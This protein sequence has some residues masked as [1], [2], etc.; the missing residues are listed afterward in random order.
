M[1]MDRLT[2]L[3]EAAR[4]GHGITVIMSGGAGAGKT[5]LVD[6]LADIA[7][8]GGFI[9]LRGSGQPR[10]VTPY[11]LFEDA[12]AGHLAEPLVPSHAMTRFTELFAVARNG[13][14]LAQARAEG[15][16]VVDTDIMAGMLTAVQSFVSDSFGDM[17]DDNGGAGTGL[18]RLEYRNRKILIE[19]GDGF[20][21]AGVIEGDEH[22]SMQEALA[23]ATTRIGASFGEAIR[24]WD[25]KMDRVSGI[26]PELGALLRQR[27]RVLRSIRDLNLEAERLRIYDRGLKALQSMASENPLFIVAEDL[28]WADEASLD[29]LLY[30]ARNLQ[31]SGAMIV[32]TMRS[33][34]LGHL[35][36]TIEK[37]R[38]EG[39]CEE[40]RLGGLG[41]GDVR[42][43]AEGLLGGPLSDDLSAA[44]S[45]RCE[46]NPLFV[47]ELLASGRRGGAMR[48]EEGRWALRAGA[49]LSSSG[50]VELIAARLR[51]LDAGW[52]HALDTCA[53]LGREFHVRD[54]ADA[55]GGEDAMGAISPLLERGILQ[56]SG[57]NVRFEHALVHEAA[58][59]FV[60]GRRSS[61]HGRIAAGME[62]AATGDADKAVYDIANHYARSDMQGKAAEFC[63]RAGDRAVAERA[64]ERATAFYESALA[65]LG[66]LPEEASST[67]RRHSLLERLGDVCTISGRFGRALSAFEQVAAMHPVGAVKARALRRRAEVMDKQGKFDQA[68]KEFEAAEAALAGKDGAAPGGEDENERGSISISQ[69]AVLMGKGAYDEAIRFAEEG[70]ALLSVSQDPGAEMEIAR[71][72]N[73][74]GVSCHDRGDIER[75]M[76]NYEKVL[77]V[78]QKFGDQIGMAKAYNNIG[79]IHYNKGEYA[80]SL[81]FMEKALEMNEAAGDRQGTA[82]T[83]NNMGISYFC[84]GEYGKAREQWEKC[85]AIFEAIGDQQ[86]LGASC[87]NVGFMHQCQGNFEM[88]LATH[89]KA[90]RM[91]EKVGD[92]RG[93][94]GSYN[95][96]A[97]AYRDMG[98]LERALHFYEEALKIARSLNDLSDLAVNLCG[99]GEAEFLAG[100]M[101]KA[102]ADASEA[103]R[104]AKEAG[105]RSTELKSLRLQGVVARERGDCDKAKEMF[106]SAIEGQK[107]AGMVPEAAMTGYEYAL[108]LKRAGETERGVELLRESLSVFEKRG[109]RALAEKCRAALGPGN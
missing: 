94:L 56:L 83:R 28:H 76:R 59:D 35:Q 6:A 108:M 30:V 38:A 57:G 62:A 80:P 64:V 86:G 17:A 54:F 48:L 33:G 18:R 66:Q 74:V 37:M 40:L 85:C 100:D 58:Y 69:A 13:V 79:L 15:G 98:H 47:R 93:V 103:H 70:I 42:V 9:A 43:M 45:E 109:M 22:G 53:C 75:A 32:G 55:W 95:S 34:P 19:Y 52:F 104:L 14:L 68:L 36:K 44:I 60:G 61:Y 2:S 21:L 81:A 82:V 27:W 49:T 12:L 51:A 107:S 16:M 96:I 73:V 23:A 84:M 29:M 3:L 67:A 65:A 87:N 11:Q 72:W 26:E 10:S 25:G 50:I 8:E 105:E 78:W 89:E 99:R 71:G 106:E 90:L 77:G 97:D 46:G 88:A 31:A 1:E 101:N 5:R 91:R 4:S 102:S 41:E 24:S 63:E 39:I 7:A 92:R 20:Y